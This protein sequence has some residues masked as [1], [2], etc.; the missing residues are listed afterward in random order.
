MTISQLK[1][2]MKRYC[3]DYI[4]YSP[5]Y[6]LAFVASPEIYLNTPRYLVISYG[7][8]L[9]FHLKVIFI[10]DIKRMIIPNISIL[11]G[12]LIGL[13]LMVNSLFLTNFEN[14]MHI[15]LRHV[16]AMVSIFG[17][18]YLI[19]YFCEKFVSVDV[20]GIGDLKLFTMGG[21]WL[22]INGIYTAT[23]VAFLLA[24]IYSLI[25]IVLGKYAK[26]QPYPFGPFITVAILSVWIY[27]PF[28]G[29]LQFENLLGI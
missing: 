17:L 19:K 9:I 5:I 3:A 26:F 4:R 23:A 29:F 28:W 24:G 22:G 27:K 6:L 2:S 10:N 8:A 21:A 20:L 12:S 7:I 25:G 11:S 13:I 16:A 15:I 14:G 18:L 1:K